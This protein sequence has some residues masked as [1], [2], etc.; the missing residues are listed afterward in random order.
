[1]NLQEDVSGDSPLIKIWDLEKR[2]RQGS[3]ISLRTLST[4]P[5]NQVIPASSLAISDS[6]NLMAVGFAN[7][8]II[9]YRG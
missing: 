4:S 5:A 8:A 2:D 1:M 9:L 3:P 7:G 6:A